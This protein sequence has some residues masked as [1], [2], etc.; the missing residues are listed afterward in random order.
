MPDADW[1][2]QAPRDDLGVAVRDV[3]HLEAEL[4]RLR[5]MLLRIAD[6]IDEARSWESLRI[7]A[8]AAQSLAQDA[9]SPKRR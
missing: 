7:A 9:L 6:V 1:W 5:S 4:R 8:R 2:E 3:P